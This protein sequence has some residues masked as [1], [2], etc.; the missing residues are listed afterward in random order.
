[1][2]GEYSRQIEQKPFVPLINQLSFL[3][4]K[5]VLGLGPKDTSSGCRPRRRLLD[6]R[7]AWWVKE[8]ACRSPHGMAKGLITEGDSC[9]PGSVR[10]ARA[11]LCVPGTRWHWEEGSSKA[12]ELQGVGLV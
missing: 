10:G 7:P 12:A 6:T 11:S 4:S 2:Q 9:L 1:M 5:K 8:S 3:L